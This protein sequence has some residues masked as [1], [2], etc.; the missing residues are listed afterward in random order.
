MALSNSILAFQDCADFL[1][2]AIS[3][4]KG[5]RLFF[6]TQKEAEFFRMRCYQFRKLHRKQNMSVYPPDHKMYGQSEYD[7]LMLTLYL[8]FEGDGYWLY[9]RKTVLD[10]GK[11]EL[12][13]EVEGPQM[14]EDSTVIEGE[15]RV[16][17]MIEGMK[18]DNEASS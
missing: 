18:N 8:T 11:L 6:K 12:L 10:P 9:A 2:P 17:K 14:L 16:V 4:E 15:G 5:A 3:D 1:E 7:E 13:S